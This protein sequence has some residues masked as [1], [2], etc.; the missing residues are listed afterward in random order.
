MRKP[1]LC[2]PALLVLVCVSCGNGLYPVSGTVTYKGQPAAGATVFFHRQGGDPLS[3]HM[4]MGIVGEDGSFSLVCG[5]QG[6]G[7]PPGE[8][9]VLI[10]W[11]QGANRGKGRVRA[12]PDR[13]K[14]RYADPRRPLL[15]ATLKA[16]ANHLPPFELTDR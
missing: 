15:H 4:I 6:K 3:E 11:K 16:E 1:L 12:M 7:A 14:G 9:A 13:L 5:D 8:Y 2:I 10:E